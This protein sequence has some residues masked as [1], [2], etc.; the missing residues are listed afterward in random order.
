M[1]VAVVIPVCAGRYENLLRLAKSINAQAVKP[2]GVVIV[3]DGEALHEDVTARFAIPAIQVRTSKHEPGMEQPRNIGTRV[4]SDLWP[5]VTHVWFLDSD[6]V[7]AP[8]CFAQIL[9]AYHAGPEQRIMVCPYPFLEAHEQP[10]DALLERD[11]RWEQFK[12]SPPDRI[13]LNDLSAGLAC[14]SGNLVWNVEEFKRVGGY[15]ANIN[16]GRCEDGELGLRAVAMQVPISF[17]K[18]ARGWHIWHPVNMDRAV[19]MNSRDVPLINE[20]HPWVERGAVYV[21]DRDG[22]SFD[23]TCRNCGQGIPTIL[24][25]R[26]AA[27]CGVAPSIPVPSDA[28]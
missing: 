22:K 13:Y 14:F 25:W 4:A 6:L 23:V 28:Q 11:M 20:R 12:V 17:C 15:W 24:W 10:V 5:D 3:E 7:L 2:A 1:K 16:H 21:E 27:E 26:H 19:E 9:S 8:D 18:E